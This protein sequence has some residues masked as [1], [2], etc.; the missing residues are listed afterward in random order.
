MIYRVD[1]FPKPFITEEPVTKVALKEENVTLT[2]RAESTAA[3]PMSAVWKKDNLVYKGSQVV[4]LARSPDGRTSYMTSELLLQNITD[5]DA[6]RYQCVVSN[7]FG[8]TYSARAKI[9]VHG[10]RFWRWFLI[11]PVLLFPPCLNSQFSPH[12]RKHQVIFA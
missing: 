12:S 3:S 5:E 6:G 2:C 8:S 10:N 7:D 9:T 1:D 4:T 11:R